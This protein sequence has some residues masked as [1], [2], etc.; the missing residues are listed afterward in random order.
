M[1]SA[2]HLHRMK[3]PRF[4]ICLLLASLASIAQDA[5]SK[6]DR[7]SISASPEPV[8]YVPEGYRISWQDEFDGE[9]LDRKNWGFPS[10]KQRG[11]AELNTPGTTRLSDGMLYLTTLWKD[12]KVHASYITTHGRFTQRYGYFESRLRF[13]KHQ[14][15]HGAFWVQTA[16]FKG[17]VDKPNESGTEIDIIEWFGS[18]RRRGWAGMNI[19]YWGTLP[20]GEAGKIRSPS[21][22]AFPKMGGPLESHPT[23]PMGDLSDDFRVYGML[24]TPEKVVIYCDGVEIMRD[25]EAVSQIPQHV[26]LSLLCAEWERPRLDTAKLPDGMQVDYVRVYTKE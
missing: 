15:H 1:E 10:Y 20:N 21:I 19:Y 9:A 18:G 6:D 22:P 25:T 5:A 26:V 12:E 2:L 7:G 11:A 23:S 16:S 3:T 17:A 24:W 4:V 8:S 14:G 13:H